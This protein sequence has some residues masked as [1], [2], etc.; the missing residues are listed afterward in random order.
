MTRVI[1]L[2]GRKPSLPVGV[3]NGRA[4]RRTVRGERDLHAGD[5]STRSGV[6]Q[7]RDQLTVRATPG[8]GQTQARRTRRAFVGHVF[9]QRRV[10]EWDAAVDDLPGVILV[11]QPRDG[12]L[13]TDAGLAV[14]ANPG[15]EDFLQ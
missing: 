2:R 11:S 9:G 5:R 10:T 3:R 14:V 15:R 8:D 1:R 12:V 4:D 7:R 13:E 6:Y